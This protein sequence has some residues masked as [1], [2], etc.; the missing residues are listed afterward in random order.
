M[1]PP[2][3]AD[4]PTA[5]GQMMTSLSTRERYVTFLSARILCSDQ[6]FSSP[7]G[8][9][10]PTKLPSTASSRTVSLLTTLSARWFK[11]IDNNFDPTVVAPDL[12]S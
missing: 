11:I 1:E 12:Q 6:I 2:L 7:C 8:T 4:L 5:G 10:Q 3:I 9:P